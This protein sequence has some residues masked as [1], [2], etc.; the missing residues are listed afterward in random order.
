MAIFTVY[1]YDWPNGDQVEEGT[2]VMENG[3]C[4]EAMVSEVDAPRRDAALDAYL[5]GDDSV[6][7]IDYCMDTPKPRPRLIVIEWAGGG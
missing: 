2:P 3:A 5:R 6:E 7:F 1:D 4:I